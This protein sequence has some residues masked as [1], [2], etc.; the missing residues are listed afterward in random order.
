MAGF[1]LTLEAETAQRIAASERLYR[2][3]L[4]TVVIATLSSAL[5]AFARYATLKP[6]NSLLA[7]LAM[8]FFLGDSF[9]ALV[10]R[11]CG[12]VRLH[13]YLSAQTAGAGTSAAQQLTDLIR[14]IAGATENLGGI[15]FGIGLLLFFCLFL[16]SRYIP[17][18]LSALGLCASV[19]WT[20]LYFANLV[21]PEQHVLFQRIC[22]PL[23]G[24]ADVT[25][26]FYLMLFAV[27][28]GVHGN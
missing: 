25:T 2:V 9:L 6:V 14:S 12:F 18:V 11:M 27:K 4:S 17:R 15:C 10:V 3:G 28:T 8:I 26:G 7:Q 1:A 19:I 20:G 5:L 16:K 13:L 23:M 24:L 22:F 21:F